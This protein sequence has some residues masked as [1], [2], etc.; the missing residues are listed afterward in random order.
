MPV[1]LNPTG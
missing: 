1:K